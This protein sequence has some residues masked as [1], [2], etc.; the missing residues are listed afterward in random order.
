MLKL[1]RCPVCHS[2]VPLEAIKCRHCHHYLGF[3][4]RWVWEEGVRVAGLVAMIAAAA[5]ATR[6]LE[7]SLLAQREKDA[8]LVQAQIS[9]RERDALKEDLSAGALSPRQMEKQLAAVPEKRL[10]SAAG[11]TSDARVRHVLEGALTLKKGL[12]AYTPAGKSPEEGF[13]SSGFVCYLLAQVGALDP[14]YQRTFSVAR[15]ERAFPS[16][17]PEKAR[18]G[19]LVFIGKAFV[20]ISLGDDLAVGMASGTG[21]QVFTI[22]PTAQ[23]SFRRWGYEVG[24]K[25]VR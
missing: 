2:M 16:V 18:A 1:R 22:P 25:L 19:D 24:S 11:K 5:V 20:A 10:L 15:L 13:D 21:V 12:V 8:A 7:M 3:S 6:S 17:L 4:F 14:A 9:Q 23:K